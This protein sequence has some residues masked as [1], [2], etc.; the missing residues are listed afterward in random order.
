MIRLLFTTLVAFALLGCSHTP[1]PSPPGYL[2]PSASQAGHS[3]V[4][5]RVRL[6]SYLDR[7]G[8]VMQLSDSEIQ[9]ARH[10][11]WAEPLGSQLQR[12]LEASLNANDGDENTTLTV[13]LSRFQGMQGGEEN[14]DSAVIT[15]RWKLEGAVH[16]EG[17]I[18]WQTPLEEGGYANLV[19]ALDAGWQHTATEIANALNTAPR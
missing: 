3:T 5:V 16:K 19:R 4:T 15:G 2:L 1:P 11:R 7:G 10:H 12:A 6:A 8:I 17:L 13:E 18:Q 14:G 9:V